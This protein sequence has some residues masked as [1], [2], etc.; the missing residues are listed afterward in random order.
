MK[1]K[2]NHQEHEVAEGATLT[3]VLASLGLDRPG[4]AVALDGKVVR[5]ADRATTLVSEG[6]D[7]TVIR[8]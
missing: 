4:I 5:A 6:A 7:I 2:I 8:G 1:I 3:D